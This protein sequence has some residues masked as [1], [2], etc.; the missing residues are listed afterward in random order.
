M[1]KL[2]F[3]EIA[4]ISLQL[5]DDAEPITIS[6]A[7]AFS[8]GK[9]AATQTCLDMTYEYIKKW[10]WSKK[11]LEN[12]IDG[13]IALW[14]ALKETVGEAFLLDF[15]N[16]GEFSYNVENLTA[17]YDEEYGAM[18][19]SAF[20]E[21]KSVYG[22]LSADQITK[23]AYRALRKEAR[24]RVIGIGHGF[25]GG[26]ASGIG[27]EFGNVAA[28]L[29]HSIVNAI[30]NSIDRASTN[31]KLR[32]FYM[33]E[34][35]LQGILDTWNVIFWKMYD[36]HIDLLNT[37][38]IED[39]T[40][41][42]FD[43]S[44]L[45]RL[46]D[47]AYTIYQNIHKADNISTENYFNGIFQC[48]EK[49]PFEAQYWKNFLNIIIFANEGNK[50]ISNSIFDFSMEVDKY[51]PGFNDEIASDSV[52]CL[53]NMHIENTISN[54]EYSELGIVAFFNENMDTESFDNY[55]L[56]ALTNIY[57]D[58]DIGID[59]LKVVLDLLE[60]LNRNIEQ[61]LHN[62]DFVKVYEEK[63]YILT[64]KYIEE[65]ETSILQ[66]LV[67]GT[68][69][70]IT[71]DISYK[72]IL[73]D[74]SVLLTVIYVAYKKILNENDATITSEILNNID[75]LKAALHVDRNLN[76]LKTYS[77]LKT[78]LT[79][80]ETLIK[81]FYAFIDGIVQ[82]N[83]IEIMGGHAY[84]GKIP[85]DIRGKII[86]N[87]TIPENEQILAVFDDTVFNSGKQGLVLTSKAIYKKGESYLSPWC[88]TWEDV[89]SQCY[90]TL[91]EKSI[92]I[93]GNENNQKKIIHCIEFS[94]LA[95][96][97]RF[98]ALSNILQAACLIFTGRNVE[99]KNFE[100]V[101]GA[102]FD[103]SNLDD[104]SALMV[105]T[106][107]KEQAQQQS[108]NEIQEKLSQTENKSEERYNYLC[109]DDRIY[110]ALKFKKRKGFFRHIL[111]AS[112][113]LTLGFYGSL[114]FTFMGILTSILPIDS[115]V[116]LLLFYLIPIV[117]LVF[118]IKKRVKYIKEKKPW[119]E[120]TNSGKKDI[121][122][123]FKEFQEMEKEYLG[124]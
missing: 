18:F 1:T 36:N 53:L 48:I 63:I 66:A 19:E 81:R 44:L 40:E 43:Y 62:E 61:Y 25:K 4:D 67:N 86:A 7:K 110:K 50:D 94:G 51:V 120:C 85:N 70:S 47:S 21:I 93:E 79:P 69:D 55:F 82:E 39:G 83:G 42:L 65:R 41:H 23:E 58:D 24:G 90:M 68:I 97:I 75:R 14:R 32:N 112:W 16:Q 8:W 111:P 27:A 117:L 29:G 52:E 114:A 121:K 103:M 31:D 123:V 38:L 77:V 76:E 122:E 98:T 49:F 119:K 26:I 60:K 2:N 30:G 56:T 54:D 71:S 17:A 74:E 108:S 113:I 78:K 100:L 105:N 46:S 101:A 99:I 15:I 72:P 88:I 109:E 20:S 12:V 45:M 6:A 91:Y 124:I 35:T 102:E 3:D 84:W 5:G 22:G 13:Y 104:Y 73:T 118:G 96:N 28:G 33:Q 9:I 87:F 10:Y 80:I 92:Y 116:F 57:K 106:D 64:K 115:V 59:E 34:S 37:I 11:N 95:V 107:S 89:I